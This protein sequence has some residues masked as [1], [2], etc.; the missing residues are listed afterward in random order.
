MGDLGRSSQRMQRPMALIA[1][2]LFI[3]ALAVFAFL[4]AYR[5]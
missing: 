4:V 1:A 2:G 3:V 5:R